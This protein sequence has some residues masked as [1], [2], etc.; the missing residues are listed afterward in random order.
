[1]VT[2]GSFSGLEGSWR[3]LGALLGYLEDHDWC[4]QE[5]GVTGQG[6]QRGCQFLIINTVNARKR[7]FIHLPRLDIALVSLQQCHL[8]MLQSSRKKTENCTAAI[9]LN[10]YVLHT[11]VLDSHRKAVRGVSCVQDQ[12][13]DMMFQTSFLWF[14]SSFSNSEWDKIEQTVVYVI[15]FQTMISRG[16]EPFSKQKNND[17]ERFD[18]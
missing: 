18:R 3:G 2:F 14:F 6:A 15:I 17:I 16:L 10:E 12:F 9:L 7:F 13:Q 8:C 11:H 4:A 5:G 1:M